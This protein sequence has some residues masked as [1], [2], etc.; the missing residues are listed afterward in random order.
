MLVVGQ[1]SCLFE[2]HQALFDTDQPTLLVARPAW[3]SYGSHVTPPSLQQ[4]ALLALFQPCF[5]LFKPAWQSKVTGPSVVEQPIFLD[6]Q[7]HSNFPVL[8]PSGI[9][10]LQSYGSHAL[11]IFSQQY[12]FFPSDHAASQLPLPASQ[13]YA[14]CVVVGHSTCLLSQHQA[15]LATGQLSGLAAWQSYGSHALVSS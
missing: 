7:H 13:S 4:Y 8:H 14:I 9:P 15:F 1:P 5:Q 11:C 3:Q 6:S 10:A 12:S 2:Q